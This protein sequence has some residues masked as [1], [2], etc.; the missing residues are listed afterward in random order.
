MAAGR[1]APVGG[2]LSLS[3]GGGNAYAPIQV[4]GFFSESNR[5]CNMAQNAMIPDV[6]QI[7]NHATPGNPH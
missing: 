5:R 7:V 1:E 4:G 6:K 3:G 2:F